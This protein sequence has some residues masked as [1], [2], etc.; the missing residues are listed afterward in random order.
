MK[1][2][3]L[4]ILLVCFV[5]L[6]IFCSFFYIGFQAINYASLNSFQLFL[7]YFLLI[8]IVIDLIIVSI[9]PFL[10]KKAHSK[11]DLFVINLLSLFFV[12][13]LC[14]VLMFLIDENELKKD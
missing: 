2:K 1:K 10:L 6:N 9:Y 14:G 11:K 8:I 4:E 3:T 13:P 12:N 7:F 5:I